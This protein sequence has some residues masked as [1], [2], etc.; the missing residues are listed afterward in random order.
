MF[1]CCSGRG[2]RSGLHEGPCC[3]RRLG[4]KALSSASASAGHVATI[5]IHERK[6]H[7]THIDVSSAVG[8][9]DS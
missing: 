4:W 3:P 6:S 7:L 8:R 9:D 2:S 5:E 1:C